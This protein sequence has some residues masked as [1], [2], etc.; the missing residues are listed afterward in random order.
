MKTKLF[1]IS[2]LAMLTAATVALAAAGGT[3]T[4]TGAGSQPQPGA[5]GTMNPNT[6][7]NP[8]VLIQPGQ[9]SNG[10]PVLPPPQANASTNSGGTGIGSNM[11]GIAPNPIKTPGSN[12]FTIS[13]NQ[14][15]LR[16]NQ[17]E[18]N[19]LTPTS[20]TNARPRILQTPLPR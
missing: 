12:Q 7:Q 13:T 19:F 9:V 5:P 17:F 20:R 8:P 3:G 15:T 14:F 16:T 2:A 6:R 1:A 18:T 11:F 10:V 4:G